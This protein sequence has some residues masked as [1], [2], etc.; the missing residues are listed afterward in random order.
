MRVTILL[1]I[2]TCCIIALRIGGPLDQSAL[3]HEDTLTNDLEFPEFLIIFYPNLLKPFS[4]TKNRMLKGD[5][6]IEGE[7]S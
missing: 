7:D 2:F 3:R 6:L 5:F 4:K 1:F